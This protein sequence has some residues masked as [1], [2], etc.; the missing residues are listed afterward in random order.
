VRDAGGEGANEC[1]NRMFETRRVK[2]HLH[3]Y[4]AME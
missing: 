2:L 1:F 3:Q 4:P